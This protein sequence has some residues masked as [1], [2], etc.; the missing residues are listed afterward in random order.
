MAAAAH[1][2]SANRI[3]TKILIC[4]DLHINRNEPASELISTRTAQSH[5]G[6]RAPAMALAGPVGAATRAPAA[7]ATALLERAAPSG[8]AAKGA[9][10]AAA[11]TDIAWRKW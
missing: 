11:R 9:P 8:E 6:L 1:M 3:R 5:G 4:V 2:L 10:A 7:G